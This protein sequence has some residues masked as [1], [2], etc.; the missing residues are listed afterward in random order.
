M[1]ENRKTHIIRD[2]NEDGTA[3]VGCVLLVL[4]LSMLGTV[5]LNLASHEVEGAKAT[6]EDVTAEYL[7]ES[8][9]DLVMRWFHDR[10]ATPNPE[11]AQAFTKRFELLSSGPSFFDANGVSQFTGTP[12]Q[13]DVLLDATRAEDDRLLNDLEHGSFR[14]LRMLGRLLKVRIYGPVRPGLLCTV[15][16]TSLAGGVSRTAM[17]QLGTRTIPPLRAGVQLRTGRLVT[18]HKVDLPLAVWLHWGDLK[19]KGDVNLGKRDEI[20]TKTDFAQVGNQSYGDMV[21]PEDRWLDLSTGGNATMSSG[22]GSESLAAPGNV[23]PNRD[24]APGLSE[25]HWDYETMKRQARLYG[26]YYV[27]GPDGLLYANGLIDQG[28]GITATELF[29]SATLGDHRGLVFI[30]TLDQQPPDMYNL[31]TLLVEAEYSEG[32]FIVNGH[33][34]WRPRG[35]GKSIPALSPP[36]EET[37]SL[38]KRIPAQLGGIHLQGVLYVAG[39]LTY[40]GRPRMYGALV[41]EGDLFTTVGNSSRLE[42]WYNYDLRSGLVRGM[43]LVYVAPGTWQQRY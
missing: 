12:D 36:P 5:S 26:S 37:S 11:V 34:H 24:P 30:D 15:E 43:P 10:R 33:L 39:N 7:A 6:V 38:A 28:Q 2:R 25:D 21:A 9:A 35:A 4:V 29:T 27:P 13:P 22:L 3:L 17:F 32:L 31:A 19:V 20:P 23:H 18:Y 1:S 40:D 41:T 14:S 42:V 8:G 16:V